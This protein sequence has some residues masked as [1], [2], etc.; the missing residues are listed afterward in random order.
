[1]AFTVFVVGFLLGQLMLWL[2][3]LGPGALDFERIP[4]NERPGIAK[5]IVKSM[6]FCQ[7]KS[8]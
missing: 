6:G 5:G 7:R 1:M 2:V 3:G 4:E 8:M